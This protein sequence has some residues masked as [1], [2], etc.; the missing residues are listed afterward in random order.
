MKKEIS[1]D[2]TEGEGAE[3][4]E[5][6]GSVILKRLNFTEKNA[7]EEEST[8]IK[9]LGNN[10]PPVIK[11]STSKMKEFALLKCIVASSLVKTTYFEDKSGKAFVPVA[12]NYGLADLEGIRNLPQEIGDELFMAYTELNA[13]SE[14]KNVK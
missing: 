2:F 8:D 5:L 11:V 6:K 10:I 14:K 3:K 13:V 7:L 4:V 1:I 9:I 12:N